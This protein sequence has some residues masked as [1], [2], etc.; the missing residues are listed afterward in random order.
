MRAWRG[1]TRSGPSACTASSVVLLPIVNEKT[2]LGTL[3]RFGVKVEKGKDGLHTFQPPGSPFPVHFRFADGYA[4]VTARDADTIA[5]KR[6]LKPAVVLPA[7][8]AST[9]SAS[10]QLGGVPK[11][12]RETMLGQLELRL[13]DLKEKKPDETK[14]QHAFR[15]KA[16]DEGPHSSRAC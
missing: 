15:V 1:S 7:K 4:H 9:L 14:S 3:E 11:D 6:L 10:L 2:V 12:L 8:E 16:V 13:A 5:V